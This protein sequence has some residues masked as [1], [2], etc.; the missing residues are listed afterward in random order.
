MLGVGFTFD[1]AAA[2]RGEAESLE[3]MRTLIESDSRNAERI[4]PFIGG[5]EVNTSPTHVHHRYI[6]DFFNRPLGRRNDLKHWS[7]MS[8]REREQ[9]LTRGLVPLDYTEEVAEDWPDLIEIIRCRVKP[10]RDK[11]TRD[12]LRVRWW[13][14]AEKR[15]GLYAAIAPLK[16][17]MVNSSKASPQFAIGVLDN[18]LVYSQN[19]NVFAMVSWAEFAELQSRTHELWSRFMGTNMK[20]DFTY[21]KDDCFETFPF[22]AHLTALPDLEHAGRCYHEH[23]AALMVARGEG[24][25]KTYNR[26]HARSE[27]DSDIERLRQLHAEM[28]S[29]V[30][31]AYGWDDLATAASPEFVEQEADEGRTPKTRLDWPSAFK[32]EVLARLLALNA[33]RAAEERAAGLTPAAADEDELVDG[34][35]AA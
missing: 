34:N 27:M 13:Q 5:E 16:R 4:H 1:D 14:Y 32:D 29:A 33:Q 25:T 31:V 30:L 15:P 23:R 22:L 35:E 12:A 6:I 21:V 19:L 18:E 26:F 8:A 10:D 9:C 7:T 20:D 24:L 11:Q 17:V 3:T 2:A 28:D